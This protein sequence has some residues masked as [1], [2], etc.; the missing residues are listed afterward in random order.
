M[1]MTYKT[2]YCLEANL[3]EH[4]I[5][6]LIHLILYKLD[7]YHGHLHQFSMGGGGVTLRGTDKFV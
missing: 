6:K 2:N 7:F 4:K 5:G 1:S 3:L